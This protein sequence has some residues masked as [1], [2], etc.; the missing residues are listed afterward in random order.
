MLSGAP[1][2]VEPPQEQVPQPING[3]PGSDDADDSSIRAQDA[4]R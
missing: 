4:S 3:G 2:G 1:S